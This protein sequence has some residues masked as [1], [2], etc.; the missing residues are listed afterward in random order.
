[1]T[2]TRRG[3]HRLLLLTQLVAIAT[4]SKSQPIRGAGS[5]SSS[6]HRHDSKQ[7]TLHRRQ[8]NNSNYSTSNRLLFIFNVFIII[9]IINIIISTERYSVRYCFQSTSFVTKVTLRENCSS[10]KFKNRKRTGKGKK[11]SILGSGAQSSMSHETED[12]DLESWR[13]HHSRPRSVE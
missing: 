1:V 3:R 5:H 12:I 7:F 4:V 8:H 11:R 10:R 6:E 2:L 13:R 9:I